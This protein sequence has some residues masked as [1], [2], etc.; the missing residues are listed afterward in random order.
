MV[1][2]LIDLF[3]RVAGRETG[4]CTHLV[5]ALEGG[6]GLA[7][8]AV[9]HGEDGVHHLARH[10]RLFCWGFEAPDAQDMSSVAGVLC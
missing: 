7:H 10:L 4:V 2:R 3:K 1:G 6:D 5:R 8:V 9:R